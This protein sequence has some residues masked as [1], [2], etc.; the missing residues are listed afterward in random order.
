MWKHP[1]SALQMILSGSRRT[2]QSL[3][4]DDCIGHALRWPGAP[5][6]RGDGRTGPLNRRGVVSPL[7]RSCAMGRLDQK[8]KAGAFL[9]S[10]M[11]HRPSLKLNEEVPWKI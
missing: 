3:T 5:K 1:V 8:A 7:R 9:T 6:G 2:K 10:V 11:A 4:R